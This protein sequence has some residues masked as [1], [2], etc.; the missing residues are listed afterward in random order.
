[1]AD[2]RNARKRF[3]H[4]RLQA[5]GEA[6]K[7]SPAPEKIMTSKEALSALAPE[8]KAAGQRGHSPASLVDLLASEGLKVSERAVAQMLRAD[9]AKSARSKTDSG[10]RSAL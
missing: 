3:D 7:S 1:M 4:V 9:V 5:L 10:R 6:L 8:L 2:V